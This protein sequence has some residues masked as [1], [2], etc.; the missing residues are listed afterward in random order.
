MKEDEFWEQK[1]ALRI[2]GFSETSS[3]SAPTIEES[4]ALHMVAKFLQRRAREAEAR[5]C[6][7]SIRREDV[8]ARDGGICHICKKPV[9]SLNWHMDHI[10][11]LSLGGEHIYKNV[12]VSHPF[13]NTSKGNKILSEQSELQWTSSR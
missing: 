6:G 3:V 12:A 1:K 11:P 10:I 9:D 7:E 4:K 2:L 8:Y 13:C 5:A